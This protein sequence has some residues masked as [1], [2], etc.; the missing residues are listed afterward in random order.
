MMLKDW[1]NIL[2]KRFPELTLAITGT[3]ALQLHDI[4]LKRKPHDLDLLIVGSNG[5]DIVE[6]Y[7]R[8]FRFLYKYGGPYIDWTVEKWKT[9]DKD[10]VVI[11]G[12]ICST[13]EGVLKAKRILINSGRLSEEK[14][15][16]HRND[17]IEIEKQL[18][19][20]VE[21]LNNEPLS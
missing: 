4:D 18:R 9:D 17:I 7:L 13:V 11:D 21:K 15:E 16:K 14:I 3:Y 20:G 1:Y 5:A 2:V 8:F 19:D 6:R 10:Y 12:I